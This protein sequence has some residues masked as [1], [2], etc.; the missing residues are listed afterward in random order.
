MYSIFCHNFHLYI[1]YRAKMYGIY[2]GDNA[3]NVSNYLTE[4]RDL[5]LLRLML[6]LIQFEKIGAPL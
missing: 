1:L 6:A 3:V 5:T 4:I 2:P